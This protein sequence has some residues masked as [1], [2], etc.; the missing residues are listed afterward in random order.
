MRILV[1]GCAGFIGFHVA[2]ALIARGDSVVGFDCVNDYYD[3]RLKESRLANGA[4]KGRIDGRN[5]PILARE[6]LVRVVWKKLDLANQD[7]ILAVAT[8]IL[9]EAA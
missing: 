1:T 7:D 6:L 3:A 5:L 2:K 4:L 8:D 9:R